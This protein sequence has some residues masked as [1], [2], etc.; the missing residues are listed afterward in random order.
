[1][2]KCLAFVAV[3]AV[4]GCSFSS[5]NSPP[6]FGPSPPAPA[7]AG[8]VAGPVAGPSG[9]GML[10]VPDL[11]GKTAAEADAALR[12]AGFTFDRVA[13][14]D[15]LCSVA[16][17]TKMAPQDTVCEQRPP[18]GSESGPRLIAPTVTIEHDTYEHGGVGGP[19]EW[20][21]M[22]DLVG[23]PLDVARTVLARANLPLADHFEL[24][25]IAADDCQPEQVCT[26]EP[27][28]STRKVLARKGRLYVGKAR[29]PATQPA[30]PTT[31]TTGDTYF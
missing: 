2:V 14:D 10:V 27:A 17:E 24:V 18:A 7:G 9:G 26:T 20:R 22:P 30:Q 8:P 5:T 29:A 16:D 31:P 13:I 15:H 28:A 11:T 4:G 25:E 21:R 12:A 23:K 6:V 1:M 3:V 19:S